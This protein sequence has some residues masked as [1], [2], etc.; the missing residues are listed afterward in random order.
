M[1]RR[2]SCLT[3]MLAAACVPREQYVEEK[4]QEFCLSENLRSQLVLDTLSERY[5]TQH[6]T[7]TGEVSYNPDKVVRFVSWVEGLVMQTHF[8]LGDFVKQG[9]VLATLKSP[10]LHT[11]LAEKKSLES[12]RKLAERKLESAKGLY[13]DQIASDRDLVEATYKLEKLDADLANLDA[14]LALFHPNPAQGVFEIRSPASGYIVEKNI[15]TGMPINDGDNLF[16]VSGLDDVWVMANVYATDMQFVQQG[17]DVEI[18]TLAYPGEIFHGRISALPQV[19]DSDERVLKARIVIPNEGLKLKPGMSADI[20]VARR[21]GE[22]AIA[23]PTDAVI[24]DDN[25]YFA[26]VYG[27]AC[28]LQLRRI[29]LVARDNRWCFVGEGLKAGECVIIEN[30]LLIYEKIKG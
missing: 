3:L 11:L 30:H 15:N 4:P 24:F 27:G 26:V 18:R 17:M 20:A 9:Q 2:Y 6:I 14:N 13:T 16:T 25:Q 29:S 28:D 21:T 10:E 19:F 22:T 7:L 5:V 12:Q 8:S 1:I 23:L